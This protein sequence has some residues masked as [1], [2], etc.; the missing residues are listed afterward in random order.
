MFIGHFAIGFASKK[1]APHTS[2]ALLLAAPLLL[3]GRSLLARHRD[4][5][6]W[7]AE[8]LG[9]GLDNAPARH[10]TLSGWAA[11]RPRP[12]ELGGGHNGSRDGHARPG[13]LAIRARNK[14]PRPRRTI[15]LRRLCSIAVRAV[16]R[17]LHWIS[18]QRHL[19][20]HLERHSV[21]IY[22]ARVGVVVRPPQGSIRFFQ[23][24]AKS[25]G[26]APPTPILRWG[27]I[28]TFACKATGQCPQL[29]AFQLVV[30][31]TSA[32]SAS[33]GRLPGFACVGFW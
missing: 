27:N 14:T 24:I 11:I 8:P 16:R 18:A 2:L 30:A 23:A 21:R 5:L 20:H 19:R 6:D 10:A 13:S 28:P 17:R 1:Y 7:R 9:S 26:S 15:C 33:S 12:M 25:P 29:R 4:H 22:S 32:H 31:K 3:P